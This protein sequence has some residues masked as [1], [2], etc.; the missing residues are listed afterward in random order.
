MVKV[1]IEFGLNNEIMNSV[2]ALSSR[3]ENWWSGIASAPNFARKS[4]RSKW[5]RDPTGCFSALWGEFSH[6]RHFAWMCGNPE[7]LPGVGRAVAYPCPRVTLYTSHRVYFLDSTSL[8]HYSLIQPCCCYGL[9]DPGLV[10]A[11]SRRRL[12]R[13]GSNSCTRSSSAVGSKN[14]PQRNSTS[15]QSQVR[16]SRYLALQKE[17]TSF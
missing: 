5:C 4:T 3:W 13:R 9:T 7:S 15:G 2:C 8:P 1:T 16:F 12:G 11:L 6:V 10:F 17:Q 14:G